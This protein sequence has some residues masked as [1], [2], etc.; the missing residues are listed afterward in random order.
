MREK[1]T[2]LVTVSSMLQNILDN[3]TFNAVSIK[4]K[5]QELLKQQIY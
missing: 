5:G 4:V 1:E 3:V 2:K